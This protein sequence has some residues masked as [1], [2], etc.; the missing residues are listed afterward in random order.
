[1]TN[2]PLRLAAAALL[3]LLLFCRLSDGR[4]QV[5]KSP[6]PTMAPLARYLIADQQEEVALART[7]AP[8]S[9]SDAAD[10]MVLRREGFATVVKGTNGFVCI[11]ERSWAKQT[12]DAEFWN[13]KVRA[14]TCFNP[15]A[16]TTFLPIFL[17]K[18][19]LVLAGASPEK[20]LEATTNAL[21][22]NQVPPLAQGAMCYM[23]SKQQYLSDDDMSWHPHLMFFVSGDS[24]GSWGANLHGSPLIA[25]NDP[26]ERVTVMMMVA[27]KWSDGT[28]G[29]SMQH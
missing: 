7:A 15:A 26:E 11:V 17:L 4:S 9:I 13:P 2:T 23:M 1:M 27:G 8:A 5:V 19:K 18:T 28:S 20:I 10:V 24:A 14:P 12:D 25:G 21:N 3:P 16:A 29:A 6:Y 22:R